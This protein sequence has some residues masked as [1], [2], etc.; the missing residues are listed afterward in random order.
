MRSSRDFRSAYPISMLE[1]AAVDADHPRFLPPDPGRN[2][3]A[4][5]SACTVDSMA[6]SLEVL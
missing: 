2:L 6:T 1:L 3:H 5:Q 4:Q